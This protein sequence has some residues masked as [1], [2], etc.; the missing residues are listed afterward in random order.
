MHPLAVTRDPTAVEVEVQSSYL[1]MF[2]Q[3]DRSFVPRAFGWIL[4]CFA[5]SYAGYQAVDTR[6]HDIEHTLQGTLCLVRLLKARQEAAGRPELT[7]DLFQLGLL[8]ILLHDTGYLKRRG[9]NE[10]TGAKY[11]VIHVQRSAEFADDLL[12]EKGFGT[13]DIVAVQN[14]IHCTGVKVRL[15]AIPFQSELER[16]VAF[17]VGTADL[18]GQM[19]AED[20]VDKLPTLYAEF[21]EAAEFSDGDNEFIAGFTSAEDLIRK[22]P[23]FWKN[24]VLPKLEKDF[25]GLYRFLNIPYP[26]GP[27]YY[28]DRIQANLARVEQELRQRG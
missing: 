3:G 24:F 21:A 17:S 19:A 9:D 18:L 2:P 20:Y 6:Y 27:N 12:S 4:E 10:G 5:G 28:L 15:E 14:M 7:S 23:A 25:L 16:I 26:D 1:A 11:T 8:G 13:R 22:T